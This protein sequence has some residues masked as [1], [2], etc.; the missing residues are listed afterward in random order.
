MDDVYGVYIIASLSEGHKNQMDIGASGPT[1]RPR[2]RRSG[3]PLARVEVEYLLTADAA[4]A[5]NGK[6]YLMGGG[7]DSLAVPSVDAVQLSFVCGVIIP[8]NETDYEHALSIVIQD[9]EG[10]PIAP[11][12]ALSVKSGRPPQMEHGASAHIPFAIKA[13]LK[14]PG[15]GTYTIAA[16]IDGREDSRRTF[17]LHVKQN[18]PA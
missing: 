4:E 12:L 13:Q 11:P 17:Q 1:L 16:V 8:W 3:L 7:W 14:F 18:P 10:S 5:L 2:R 6:L 9:A 15:Q